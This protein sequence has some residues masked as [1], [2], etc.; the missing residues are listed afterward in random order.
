M[1][2]K[3]IIRLSRVM[4]RFSEITTD[5]GIVLVVD[6]E[7][8]VGKEAY[9]IGIDGEVTPADGVY[10]TEDKIITIVNG[11]IES[12]EDKNVEEPAV[13]EPQTE[14]V[15]EQTEEEEP[16]GE[17][18]VEDVVDEKD[19]KIKELETRIAEL[20]AENAEL[21]EKLE[22]KTEELSK[23]EERLSAPVETPAP[24]AVKSSFLKTNFK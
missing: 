14:E 22:N 12:I 20:E 11:I 16:A 23:A 19:E 17:E 8:E 9:I 5:E 15:V 24:K 3:N 10:S 4:S 1:D 7:L 6:G 21:K 18:V 13:E 2:L